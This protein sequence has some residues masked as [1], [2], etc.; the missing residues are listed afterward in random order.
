MAYFASRAEA[1]AALLRRT[2]HSNGAKHF[3]G[4]GITVHATDLL[5]PATLAE[6]LPS[7]LRMEVVLLGQSVHSFDV[8]V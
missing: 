1:A 6:A 8:H 4:G 3:S 2:R 5:L 7:P